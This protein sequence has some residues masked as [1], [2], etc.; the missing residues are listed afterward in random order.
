MVRTLMPPPSDGQPMDAGLN[1]LVRSAARR[2]NA[3][4][5]DGVCHICRQQDFTAVIPNTNPVT[6]LD[7]SIGGI[8][9]M[10]N[11]S[12]FFLPDLLKPGDILEGRA[13]PFE[14]GRLTAGK[15]I[16]FHDRIAGPFDARRV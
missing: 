5:S 13:R 2:H 10:Y 9:R 6:G 16:F 12:V 7:A 15:R 14:T 1:R 11:D 3:P 8:V 4:S